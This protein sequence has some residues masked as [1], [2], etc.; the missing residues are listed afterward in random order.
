VKTEKLMDHLQ[1]VSVIARGMAACAGFN[2][3]VQQ[4]CGIAGYLHDIGKATS[5]GH[6]AESMERPTHHEIGWAYLAGYLRPTAIKELILD[7]VYW[8]HA[9]V[10]RGSLFSLLTQ[11]CIEDNQDHR[12]NRLPDEPP[13]PECRRGSS[14]GR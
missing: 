14:T 4:C 8:H 5:I 1:A 9:Q 2:N 10:M 3:N 11:E 12:R 7:A 6:Q 13:G